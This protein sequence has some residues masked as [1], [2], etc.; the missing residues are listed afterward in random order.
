MILETKGNVKIKKINDSGKLQ[1]GTLWACIWKLNIREK[2]LEVD[3]TYYEE[4][5]V[6][7]LSQVRQAK[8]R[9]QGMTRVLV[10]W[11]HQ[12]PLC[13]LR[14][15]EHSSTSFPNNADQ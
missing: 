5:A 7:Q 10:L 1:L 8:G 11:G 9:V 2:M 4:P 12:A 3:N 15:E 6:F 13:L 14:T